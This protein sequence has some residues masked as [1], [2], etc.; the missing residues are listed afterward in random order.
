MSET[1]V[2]RLSEPQVKIFNSPKRFVVVNAGRR[3][4]KSWLAGAK[5]FDKC[6]NYKN[7]NVIYIAP[8]LN[9]ARNIMWDTWIKEHIPEAYVAKK[10]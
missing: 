6:Q 9:M 8:T 4:G 1:T 2:Y 5:I 7:K 3:F 10:K